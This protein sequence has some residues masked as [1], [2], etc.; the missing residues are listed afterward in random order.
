MVFANYNAYRVAFQ[1][2][3]EGDDTVSN[4]FST[5]T[6][7]MLIG[8]G[9]FRVFHG[10]GQTPGLRASSMLADLSVAVASN[11]AALPADL[12]ELKEVYFSGK[13]PLEIL[14]LDRLREAEVIGGGGDSRFCAQDGDTLRFY[15]AASGTV[16]GRY[17]ARPAA[18]QSVTWANATTFARYPELFLYASLFEGAIFMGMADKMGMWEA[19]YRS[20]A[21]GANHAERMRVWNGGPL[22][23]RTR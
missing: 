2:M 21:D 18:L 1:H 7:D 9:E 20:I 15:P 10:D 14:P 11:A 12:L 19:R 3:L 22:R 8:M 17:Y 23:V 5:D 6:M 13:R 16:L 4:T